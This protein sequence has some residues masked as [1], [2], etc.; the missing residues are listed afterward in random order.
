MTGQ[1][2]AIEARFLLIDENFLEDIGIGMRIHRLK[3]GGSWG[4]DGAILDISQGS[5]DGTVTTPTEIS[6][7][8]GGG[9]GY[10]DSQDFS[11]GGPGLQFSV[12]HGG[13]MSDLQVS[14]MV[15]ATQ[16]HANSKTLTAPKVMVLNGEAATIQVIKERSYVSNISL[17]SDTTSTAGTDTGFAVTYFDQEID[18][19]PTG[20][21]MNVTPIITHD[22]KYVL[23]R[24]TTSLTKELSTNLKDDFTGVVG[25]GETSTVGWEQPTLEYT[26][27][28]TRVSVPDRGT[29]MLGGL[30]LTAEKELETGVPV[31]SK[32]PL[33]GRL[34][35]NRSEVKD[36]QVLIVLVKPTIILKEEAEEEAIA[37]LN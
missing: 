7:S 17:S 27:I 30:T 13:I 5:F 32:I 21:V 25:T 28:Q 14:F 29:V 11:G 20:I 12:G 1:Q 31:L 8:L 3:V 37:A 26:A 24:I 33:L 19:L 16:A 36:K 9:F 23:L 10:E 22:K 35:S 18:F 15:R 6:S 4:T 2:V 34:F